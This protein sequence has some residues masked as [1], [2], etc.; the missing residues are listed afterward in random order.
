MSHHHSAKQNGES[1][2]KLPVGSASALTHLR[3]AGL[4]RSAC[5]QLEWAQAA[6]RAGSCWSVV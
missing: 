6:V 5:T 1:G 4:V 2:E 3:S